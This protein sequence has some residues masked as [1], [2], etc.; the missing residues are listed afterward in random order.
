[1]W[2]WLA[3]LSSAETVHYAAFAVAYLLLCVELARVFF[4]GDL[5]DSGIYF[6]IGRALLN[7]YLPYVDLFETKPP[8]IF[9]LTAI[10]L[11]FGGTWFLR[12]VSVAFT[13]ITPFLFRRHAAFVA[14]VCV[15]FLGKTVGTQTEAFGAFFVSLYLWNLLRNGHVVWS[16]LFLL[17]GIGMKEPFLLAALAGFLFLRRPWKDFLLPL[18]IAGVAGI[19]VLA[20]TGYLVPYVSVYLPVMLGARIGD[21]PLWIRGLVITPTLWLYGYMGIMMA[22]LFVVRRKWN[23][24]AFLA[25][26]MVY[27]SFTV[28]NLLGWHPYVIGLQVVAGAVVVLFVIVERDYRDILAMF[29]MLLAVNVGYSTWEYHL[30]VALPAVIAM[31]WRLDR[32][33][34]LGVSIV[35]LLFVRPIPKLVPIVDAESAKIL[36]IVMEE[37]GIDRFFAVPIEAAGYWH[38]HSPIGP[39][40]FAGVAKLLTLKHPLMRK[41]IENA[42][43]AEIVYVQ[44]ASNPTWVDGVRYDLATLTN[45]P[46]PCA[47]VWNEHLWRPM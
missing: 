26:Y 30:A 16:A 34:V 19:C 13:L 45:E 6:T 15:F 31:A 44:D 20:I 25:I 37:C 27:L 2:R 24:L 12:L 17:L 7:G 47:S 41:T 42:Q 32:R 40:Y 8:G 21:Y 14:L 28:H 43:Y 22:I 35:G 29:L 10:S 11:L 33:I 5:I 39:I 46:L 4:M 23:V 18:A 38:R 9:Y 36:D 3:L 1:L